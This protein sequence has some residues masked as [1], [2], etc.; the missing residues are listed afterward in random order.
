MDFELL[1]I[2]PPNPNYDPYTYVHHPDETSLRGKSMEILVW[3]GISLPTASAC[4]T[5][6]LYDAGEK[7]LMVS[8]NY[9]FRYYPKKVKSTIACKCYVCL[10]KQI[11]LEKRNKAIKELQNERY[12]KR[13]VEHNTKIKVREEKMKMWVEGKSIFNYLFYDLDLKGKIDAARRALY[14]ECLENECEEM[15]LL[16]ECISTVYFDGSECDEMYSEV[17]MSEGGIVSVFSE[18]IVGDNSIAY[19]VNGDEI[20]SECCDNSRGDTEEGEAREGDYSHVKGSDED[21]SESEYTPDSEFNFLN[22][23]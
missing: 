12:Q 1:P 8:D 21:D 18:N 4:P 16:S 9:K 19:D 10:Y 14:I 3:N 23:I 2:R 13:L 5:Y 17:R 15:S 20:A 7:I 6:K 22:Y 11:D